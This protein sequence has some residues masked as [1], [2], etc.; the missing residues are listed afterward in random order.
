MIQYDS[1]SAQ[2]SVSLFC[3]LSAVFLLPVFSTQLLQP[4]YVALSPSSLLHSQTW[5]IPVFLKCHQQ[6]WVKREQIKWPVPW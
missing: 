1:F 3:M 2:T 4:S 6:E 5:T